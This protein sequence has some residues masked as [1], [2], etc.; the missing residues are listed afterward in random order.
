MPPGARKDALTQA[1]VHAAPTAPAEATVLCPPPAI[2][3]KP[4]PNLSSLLCQRIPPS[5]GLRHKISPLLLAKTLP[6]STTTF[7]KSKP[8]RSVLHTSLPVDLSSARTLPLI[9]MK[10]R[11]AIE[12]PPLSADSDKSEKPSP[13]RI[14]IRSRRLRTSDGQSVGPRPYKIAHADKPQPR[15]T[16]DQRD[17]H[18][19]HPPRRYGDGGERGEPG[20]GCPRIKRGPQRE[21]AS[22]AAA[23]GKVSEE[24]HH[25]EEEAAQECR[26]LHLH[27]GR[28]LESQAQKDGRGHAGA[29][30]Q[31]RRHWRAVTIEPPKNLRC[32]TPA[33][34]R[35]DGARAQVEIGVGT[36]KRR[37]QDDEIHH[38][39]RGRNP[40]RLEHAHEWTLREARLVPRHHAHQHG[41]ATHIE[42]RQPS[43]HGAQGVRHRD[44]RMAGFARRHRDGLRAQVA[45]DGHSDA[46]P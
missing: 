12:K 9:P 4:H 22:V 19:R 35:E 2:V 38:A 6:S 15:H 1:P 39:S 11:P 42:Q 24:D 33:G 37:R 29:G 34:Q 10:T 13:A 8:G 16:G 41:N 40:H 45:E 3:T 30:N 28:F 21:R 5:S 46:E 7:T 18:A 25:P 31:H 14:T 23:E 44:L 20:D 17:L 27:K 26:T 36:G 43:H 32:V